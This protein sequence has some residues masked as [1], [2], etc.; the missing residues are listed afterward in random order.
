[1][2]TLMRSSTGTATSILLIM[3]GSSW[4]AEAKENKMEM[5][6]GEL[7]WIACWKSVT[8]FAHW[9]E[10]AWE[11]GEPGV[12]KKEARASWAA[13]RKAAMEAFEATK[14]HCKKEG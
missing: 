11:V 6:F 3:I 5:E 1:M 4:A 12:A 9:L 14:N 7:V 13:S 10:A 8:S 2:V